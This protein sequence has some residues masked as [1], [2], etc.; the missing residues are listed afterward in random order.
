MDRVNLD[1]AILDGANFKGAS[2][3]KATLSNVSLQC[4]VATQVSPSQCVDMSHALLNGA[5]L[6]N[7]NLTGA[8]LDHASLTKD[9]PSNI[10]LAAT[11]RNAHLKN[12]NL[13]AANLSGVDFTSANFFSKSDARGCATTGS[14]LEQAGF[15]INCASAYGATI[16]G[17]DFTGA[18][19]YGVD[20]R[21]ATI[22]GATF[23]GAVL[24]ASDFSTAQIGPG[25]NGRATSFVGAFL[26]G[27]NLDTA[28]L[29]GV[30]LGKAYFDF[31]PNGAFI[32]INLSGANHNSFACSNPSTCIR[33]PPLEDVCVEINYPRTTVPTSVTM[34]CPDGT[35]GIC[36][37]PSTPTGLARWKSPLVIDAATNP[38]PPGWYH[39]PAT[40]TA[41]TPLPAMCNGKG[42]TSAIYQ[43]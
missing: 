20:F 40:Y 21:M 22:T 11:L 42:N 12:V 8:S 38:G 16:D 1:N 25:S 15:T 28:T 30:D 35:V 9:G 2:L 26:Q 6:N 34:T 19:L 13:S 41:A 27:T 32:D 33:P 17:T 5:N 4:S 31:N 3:R 24:V 36:G 43:W 39:S 7:A 37:D 18:Y 29:T 14:E 23:L 10:E